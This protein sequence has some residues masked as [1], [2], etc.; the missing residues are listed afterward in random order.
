M[1]HSVAPSFR[2]VVAT[3]FEYGLLCKENG[4]KFCELENDKKQEMFDKYS[5][6]CSA[7]FPSKEELI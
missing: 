2:E 4:V 5:R 6:W 1:E 7:A 3:M